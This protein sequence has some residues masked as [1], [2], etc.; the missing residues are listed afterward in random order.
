MGSL[1]K[2]RRGRTLAE[3]SP[4]NPDITMALMVLKM[5][6]LRKGKELLAMYQRVLPRK[7]KLYISQFPKLYF[8][9]T[10]FTVIPDTQHLEILC[11]IP[12]PQI[13]FHII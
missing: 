3:I 2:R 7:V 8:N 6:I 5:V 9:L 12:N 11:Y 13:T 1:G 4:L 10:E